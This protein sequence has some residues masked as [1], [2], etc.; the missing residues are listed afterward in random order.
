MRRLLVAPTI[1][2]LA[3]AL[4]LAV[5]SSAQAAPPNDFGNGCLATTAPSNATLVMTAKSVL[6]TLP[7]TAPMS[8][9]ITKATF[10]VPSVPTVPTFIKTMR[11]TGNPNE[12]AVIS[13]SASIGVNTGNN[14]YDVRLPVTA[15]DLLG[16]SSTLGALACNTANAGDIIGTAAGNIGVGQ[17]ATFTPVPSTAI[18][19]VATVE[20]DVD[21]DGF[22]DVTQDLCPQSAT[23]QAACPVIKIDS[24]ASASEKS[25]KVT[26][27]TSTTANVSVTGVAKV[28]GKN[29][30]LKGGSKTVQPG[31]LTDFK[32][33]LPKALKAAL[34]KLPPSKKITVTLTASA[35]DLVGRVTTD[36]TKVKLPGT[37]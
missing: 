7:I 36:T 6:N 32:V 13:Q 14:T 12:Y 22:G 26:A 28:G 8:G 10:N 30:K 1:I 3:S 21:L 19:A 16:I 18:S 35:T 37:K 2:T 5:P 25:I 11:A 27:T 4:V 29:V 17:A 34:A 31:S 20:P 33:K 15:G 23:F 9:V 24:I